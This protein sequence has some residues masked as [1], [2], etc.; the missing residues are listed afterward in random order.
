MKTSNVL[1]IFCGVFFLASTMGC[2][3]EDV[4]GG[5][6]FIPTFN[7]TWPVEGDEDRQIDLQPDAANKGVEKGIFEGAEILQTD[8]GEVQNPL[9]GS[10]DGLDIEFTITR[11]SNEKIKYTGVMIPV[12]ESDHQIV[13]IE[14]HSSEGNMALAF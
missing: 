8:S 10:F 1:C 3:S 2:G 11:E 13:R 6:T 4:G 14:L 9:E 7:A 12:S 5:V